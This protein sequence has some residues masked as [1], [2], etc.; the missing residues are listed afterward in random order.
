M[1]ANSNHN[2]DIA[3]WVKKVIDSCETPQQ[4]NK[5][6]RLMLL[7]K[8]KLD[9]EKIEFYVKLDYVRPLQSAIDEKYWER[10]ETLK[11]LKS[12]EQSNIS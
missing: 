7:F 2:G 8:D 6:R 5:A 1:S 3:M 11:K 9:R 4:I 10:L 12:N